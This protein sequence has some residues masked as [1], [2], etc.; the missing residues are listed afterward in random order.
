MKP[1]F[2]GVLDLDA[3]GSCEGYG[4]IYIFAL[5]SFYILPTPTA[6]NPDLGS[7]PHLLFFLANPLLND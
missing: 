5:F 1:E 3:K 4:G 7:E 2:Q 6:V